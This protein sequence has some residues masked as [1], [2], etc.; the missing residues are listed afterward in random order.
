LALIPV[1]GAF[2]LVLVLSGFV[3]LSTIIATA[4]TIAWAVFVVDGGVASPFGAFT[5]AM[6]LFILWTH[7]ANIQRMLAGNENRFAKV[8]LLR[9]RD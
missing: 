8:M 6:T 9:R 1:L 2:A 3:G 5:V 4:S 7:R